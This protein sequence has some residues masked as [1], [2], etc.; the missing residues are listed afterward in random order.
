MSKVLL[1]YLDD[2]PELGE[3]LTDLIQTKQII[4][5]TF[6]KPADFLDAIALAPPTIVLIDYRLPLTNGVEVA[7]KVPQEIPCAII[8]GELEVQDRPPHIAYLSKPF[9]KDL[10]LQFIEQSLAT[11][12]VA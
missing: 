10:I 12:L 7:K 11:R 3:V 4:I 9:E 1:Y 6:I 8:T 2:E 5:R